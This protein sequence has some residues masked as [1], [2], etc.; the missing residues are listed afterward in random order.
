MTKRVT[1]E[2]VGIKT[3]L[4]GTD[5][6]NELE[7]YGHLGTWKI[8]R[9]FGGNPVDRGHFIPWNFQND[10][11]AVSIPVNFI[12]FINQT[13]AEFAIEADEELWVGGHLKEDDSPPND[14]DTLGD[15][16][17]MIPH[18]EIVSGQKVVSFFDEDQVAAAIFNITVL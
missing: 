9:D 15:R 11:S 3:V 4:E 12:F 2:I 1:V 16:H 6:G 5:P 8:G 17:A 14:N 13:S 18:D 7:I 10:G